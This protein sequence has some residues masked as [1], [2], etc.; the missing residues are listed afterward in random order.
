MLELILIIIILAFIFELMDSAAG[1][2]FG[3]GLTPLL[4]IMGYSPLQI[5][6]TLLISESITGFID[7]YFGNEL[8]NVKFSFK[9]MSDATKLALI[10]AFFGCIAI[11]FSILLTYV[12]L[13]LPTIFIK[14]YVAILVLGM[15]IFAIFRTRWKQKENV[16]SNLKLMVGF[17]VIAGFNKGIGGGGYGPVITLGQIHSGVYEKSAT[18]IVSF[19]EAMVSVVGICTFLLITAV[20]VEVDLALLP[21]IFTGGFLAALLT[22]Y[23]VRV[24]PNKMWRYIIPIYAIGIGIFLL[25]KI[26]VL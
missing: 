12:A 20:G 22:P 23:L 1:M 15:G 26:F 7:A 6:P 18:A 25:L 11:F 24:L 13:E 16:T 5:V 9:P 19:S 2:G 10:I 17:S 4:L 14:Q 21:S 3:T 8:K